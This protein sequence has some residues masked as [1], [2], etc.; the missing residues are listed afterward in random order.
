[1]RVPSDE[2]YNKSEFKFPGL[3]AFDIS[4]A[5]TFIFSG[6]KHIYQK[7]GKLSEVLSWKVKLTRYR[8]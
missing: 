6:T 2:D 5:E 4:K 7:I 8:Y 1:M 3:P